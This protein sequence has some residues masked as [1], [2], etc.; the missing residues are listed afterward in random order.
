M[1]TQYTIT[2][3]LD[4]SLIRHGH[5]QTE[6]FINEALVQIT[7]YFGGCTLSRAEGTWLNDEGIL[8]RDNVAIFTTITDVPSGLKVTG[9]ARCLTEKFNQDCVLVTTTDLN[10]HSFVERV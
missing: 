1:S 6:L 7:T 3:G 8:I 5:K 2:V 9:I 10:N 4:A